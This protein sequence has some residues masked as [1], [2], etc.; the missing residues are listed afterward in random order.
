MY[1]KKMTR[2]SNFSL[3]LPKKGFDSLKRLTLS[4]KIL[5]PKKKNQN[6]SPEKTHSILNKRIYPKHYL[7]KNKF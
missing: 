3:P 5:S 4:L 7:Y 6:P 1:L 2:P